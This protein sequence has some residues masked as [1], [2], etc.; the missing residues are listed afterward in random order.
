[1]TSR[2]IQSL[3]P[4]EKRY[5]ITIDKGLSLRVQT[6]G[7]KSW[8]LRIPTNGRVIDITLGHFPDLGLQQ[9]KAEARKRQKEF[10]IDPV[11]SYT[12]NDAF[13]LWCAAKKG[14]IVSYERE[15]RTISYH[16]IRH[17]GN[18]QLDEISAPLVIKTVRC[19]EAR[20]HQ[21]TLK[22]VLM[23]LREMLDL[24]VF[25]G[26]ITHNPISKIS[27]AFAPAITTPMPS[28]DWRKLPA[29]MRVMK[30]A[31]PRLQNY[32]LFSV[33][34]MLRPGEVAMLEKSW[35]E[36][37]VITI[38]A[39]SMKKRRQHRVPVSSLMKK[40]LEREK[41]FSPH[42]RNNTFSLAES[43]VVT[44][45]SRLSQNIFCTL[46]WAVKLFPTASGQWLA[47][48]WL[49]IMSRL[50]SQNHASLMSPATKFIGHISAQIF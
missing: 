29:V 17:L 9:A 15:K 47:A 33:C 31:S 45:A 12:L 4:K 30:E 40:L 6:S 26:Y 25:A 11:A 38:P 49:I 34:S 23:R 19:I 21:C 2:T 32:F 7:T 24:A 27:K 10:D 39:Q 3:K 46:I 16:L 48:G 1:M 44:S 50:K 28:M 18:Y 5:S 13:A 8:V 14:R 36:N 42:P 37:D 41:Q 35:L 22:H 20:G 43:P